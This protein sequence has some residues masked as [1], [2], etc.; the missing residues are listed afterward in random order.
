MGRAQSTIQF[1]QGFSRG[2]MHQPLPEG[3]GPDFADGWAAGRLSCQQAVA[4]YLRQRGFGDW[5]DY[6][7]EKVLRDGGA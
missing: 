7:L 6:P 1:V 2:A 5:K 3:H 4:E